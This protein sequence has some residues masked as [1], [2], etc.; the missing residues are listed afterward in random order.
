MVKIRKE[1]RDVEVKLNKSKAKHKIRYYKA[2]AEVRDKPPESAPEY[3]D[4]VHSL[5]L[6]LTD[7]LTKEELLELENDE[8]DKIVQEMIMGFS[9]FGRR[10]FLPSS[11][12]PKG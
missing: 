5:V 2:L 3:I 8:I 12:K 11:S 6:E 7:G 10:D 4:T 9:L 1:G